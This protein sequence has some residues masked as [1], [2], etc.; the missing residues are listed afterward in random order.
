[1]KNRTLM[2]IGAFFLL[3]A[4]FLMVQRVKNTPETIT[5]TTEAREVVSTNR[6]RATPTPAKEIVIV[7]YSTKAFFNEGEQAK[8]Q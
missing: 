5:K 3:L 6:S 7:E 8:D 2:I 4:V 1:M